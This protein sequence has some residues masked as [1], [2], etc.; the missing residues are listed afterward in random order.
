[1]LS[2]KLTIREFEKIFNFAIN[3]YL[4]PRKKTTGRTSSEIRGLGGIIDA[5]TWGKLVEVGVSKLLKQYNPYK[6]YK[7]DL[8]I[9]SNADVKD[10]PDIISITEYKTSVINRKPNVFV[11]IK[12][13]S[14]NDQ[15]IGLTKEQFSTINIASSG[16]PIYFIY[17]NIFSEQKVS[18]RSTS[19]LGMYLKY[20]LKRD[21]RFIDFSA[22]NIT[23]NIQFIFSSKELLSHGYNFKKGNQLYE[24]NVFKKVEN[25]IGILF[26]KLGRTLPSV[27]KHNAINTSSY[28]AIKVYIL[29]NME[30]EDCL[31]DFQIK[32]HYRLYSKKNS[33]PHSR[34]KSIKK[35]IECISNVVIEHTV[36]GSFELSKDFIYTFNLTPILV[37][38]RNNYFIS[39]RKVEQLLDSNI[40]NQTDIT[41]KKIAELI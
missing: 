7:I 23:V 9:K 16:R 36:F 18:N 8:D 28:T 26:N 12:N 32:G 5:F 13:T 17:G 33:I 31:S 22:F 27:T 30:A 10:E 35:Y 25:K 29:N 40:I 19:L 24:S 15:W 11:E 41:M 2:I 37:L 4:D 14:E 38:N 6:N 21:K 3:Y 20:L 34:K 1:M 39:K